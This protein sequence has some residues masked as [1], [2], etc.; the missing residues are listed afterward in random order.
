M[1]RKISGIFPPTIITIDTDWQFTIII[2][3]LI[4]V[5]IYYLNNIVFKFT[6]LH[7]INYVNT[8]Y[9]I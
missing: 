9:L 6:Y 5:E 8:K 4:D 3:L 1:V 7:I 2:I